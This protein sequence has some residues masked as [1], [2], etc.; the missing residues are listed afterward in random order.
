M[1]KDYRCDE[2]STASGSDRVSPARSRSRARLGP[3]RYASSTDLMPT[4]LSRRGTPVGVRALVCLRRRASRSGRRAKPSAPPAKRRG[5]DKYDDQRSYQGELQRQ[6]KD[7][8]RD[9]QKKRDD[10]KNDQSG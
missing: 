3:G 1:S 6:T 2:V 7:A 5:A 10:D 8:P 9:E 4:D